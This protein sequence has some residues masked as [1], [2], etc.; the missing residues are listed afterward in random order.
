MDDQRWPQCV[1]LCCPEPAERI[2]KTD[3]VDSDVLTPRRV[4]HYST[5]HMVNQCKN[6]E[7]LEYPVHGFAL[8]DSEPHGR[9]QVTHI[10]CNAP[11][12]HEEIGQGVDRIWL[13]VDEG[14]A[15]GACLDATAFAVS[16][17]A[18]CA[19]LTTRGQLRLG[20][21]AH[22]LRAGDRFA[23]VDDVVLLPQRSHPP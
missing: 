16:R 14:G 11:P 18:Q 21:W 17:V 22:P 1:V 12:A 8:E 19:S 6:H 20:L 2:D 7:C 3:A 13:R 10:G 23:P 9:F 5:D 15:P 4:A